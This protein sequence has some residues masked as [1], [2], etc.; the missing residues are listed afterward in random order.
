MSADEL[1]RLR[2]RVDDIDGQL[3]E[4]LARRREVVSE[5]AVEK[6]ALGL[7]AV[8]AARE[9]ALRERWAEIAD[10]AGLPREAALAVLEAI[11]GPSRSHVV[12]LFRR[13]GGGAA[14]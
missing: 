2:A 8:D 5:L 3:V 11:L 14:R 4:L 12:E 13:D 7:G 10:R 6:R 9:T 1:A